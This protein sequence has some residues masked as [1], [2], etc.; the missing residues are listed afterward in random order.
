MKLLVSIL[1]LF[2]VPGYYIIPAGVQE[3]EAGNS[4]YPT[5]T[6][7]VIV[8]E[9]SV[10]GNPGAYTFHVG[11]KSDDT[12]CEQY[13][14][15]WEIVD[16]SGALV[17]RRI[18]AHSHVNEQPFIRSG[19][20][21]AIGKDQIVIIRGHMNKAGYG[22]KAFKGSVKEGFREV[23]PEAGFGADLETSPPLPEGCAF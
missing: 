20:P 11:L 12:G 8:T 13:A 15:W 16:N 1:T 4:T 10:S 19:G 21:V 14:D 2:L 7:K 23:T 17:Y 3:A 22:S 9:V 6:E 18:L 5:P